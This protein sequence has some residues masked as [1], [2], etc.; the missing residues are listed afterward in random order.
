[1]SFFELPLLKVAAVEDAA[2]GTV[3]LFALN[4]NL[5][6][7]MPLEVALGGFGKIAGVE[8]ALQLR[9]RSLKATNTKEQPERV[10]PA[11][12]KAV[13]V[14]ADRLHATLAPASWNVVRV[15]LLR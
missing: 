7:A 14:K 13:D 6:E 12:L 5:E 1:M 8:S 15:Q 10:A 3:T 2:S 9:H 4:R 11:Q